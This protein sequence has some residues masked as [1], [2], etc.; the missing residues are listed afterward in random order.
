MKPSPTNR[1][2]DMRRWTAGSWWR[3]QANLRTAPQWDETDL[4][5]QPAPL[6]T[7]GADGEFEEVVGVV[8]ALLQK[9]S[10]C[11][12]GCNSGCCEPTQWNSARLGCTPDIAIAPSSPDAFS[13]LLLLEECARAHTRVSVPGGK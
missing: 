1:R 12:V 3:R 6:L 4:N 11:S 8:E 5:A 2:A 7:V 13:T 9:D 10:S